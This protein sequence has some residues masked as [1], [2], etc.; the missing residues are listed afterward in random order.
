MKAGTLLKVL[1]AVDPDTMVRLRLGEVLDVNY[2]KKCAKAELINERC[3][4]FL[5]INIAQVIAGEKKE[6]VELE[7]KQDMFEDVELETIEAIYDERFGKMF[8]N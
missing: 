8:I 3:L 2:R 4:S 5:E 6:W 7:L 1:Q